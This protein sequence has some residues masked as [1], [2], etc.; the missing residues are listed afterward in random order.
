MQVRSGVAGAR[1]GVEREGAE[2]EGARVNQG[3]G[4][5]GS[6]ARSRAKD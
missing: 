5:P 6:R 3:Q 4:E 2:R 1:V